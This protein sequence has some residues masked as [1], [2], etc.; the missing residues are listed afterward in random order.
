MVNSY[1]NGYANA[2][3]QVILDSTVF[4]MLPPM[5]AAVDQ[6]FLR[7]ISEARR[8]MDV[9][10]NQCLS[11]ENTNAFWQEYTFGDITND[12]FDDDFSYSNSSLMKT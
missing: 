5:T 9:D 7:I 10:T 11:F 6:S 12:V 8:E 2:S 4:Y 1:N 3:Y